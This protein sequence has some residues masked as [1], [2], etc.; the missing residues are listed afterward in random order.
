MFEPTGYNFP[1]CMRLTTQD[2]DLQLKQFLPERKTQPLKQ[3]L[4]TIVA[5]RGE[6]NASRMAVIKIRSG[7]LP[8]DTAS[9]AAAL[10]RELHRE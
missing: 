8:V 4:V 7:G 1:L 3:A 5:N 9:G 6:R 2:D 10:F